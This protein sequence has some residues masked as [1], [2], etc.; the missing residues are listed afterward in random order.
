MH[1]SV[2]TSGRKL[3]MGMACSQELRRLIAFVLEPHGKDDPDPDIGQGADGHTMTFALLAFA[4]VILQGPCFLPRG[5]PGKLVQ[6]VA[7]GFDAGITLM[8]LG[9]VPAF[10]GYWRGASQCL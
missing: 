6:G 1:L 10:I 5:F 3:A 8:H 4:P 9:V 7:Q 2:A